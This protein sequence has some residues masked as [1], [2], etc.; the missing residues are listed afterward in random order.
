LLLKSTGASLYSTK[1]IGLAYLKKQDFPNYTKSVYVVG[2]EQEHHFNQLF[3][4]LELMWFPYDQ[5]HHI[6]Y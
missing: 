5:L 4:T 2:S 6:S 1:D 3:K